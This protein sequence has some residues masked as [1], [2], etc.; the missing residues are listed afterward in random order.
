MQRLDPDDLADLGKFLS[1]RLPC[2]S[3]D[4]WDAYLTVS[5]DAG[6]LDAVLAAAARTCDDPRLR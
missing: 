6:Q 2:P 1:R 5:Q 4:G 3:A